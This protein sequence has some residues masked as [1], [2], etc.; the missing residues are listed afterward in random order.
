M[1]MLEHPAITKAINTGY[2]GGDPIW[3]TCPCCG[4]ECDT[5]YLDDSKYALGCNKCV[6]AVDAWEYQQEEEEHGLE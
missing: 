5:I 2:P 6:Q 1:Y 4:K 3:P